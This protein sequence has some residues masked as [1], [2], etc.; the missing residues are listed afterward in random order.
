MYYLRTLGSAISIGLMLF[1]LGC[2]ASGP[3]KIDLMPAPEVYDEETLTPFVDLPGAAEAP[4]WGMLYATDRAPVDPDA[5]QPSKERFYEKERGHLVR[6]GIADIELGEG[7]F[8]WEE[9]R[10]ISL[11]KN[12]TDQYP[13]KVTAVDELGVLDRSFSGFEAPEALALK[14]P[15]PAQRF[16]A[17]INE[18]LA[19][20]AQ[21]DIFVCIHGY[22][23]VFD[24]PILVAME[25]WHYLGYEGVFVAYAWPS[26]PSRWAYFADAETAM[27]TAYGLRIFLEYL[28]EETNAERIHIIGYSQGTRSLGAGTA[29]FAAAPG[30]A[31]T[32]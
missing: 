32:C 9:A 29:I 8:S 26:T 4:Y 15:E 10:Q 31:A 6:L 13:L 28:A 16:A 2:A 14:S 24:N 23:V 22:K 7:D 17:F 5:D 11:A 27:T 19:L 25:L 21:K 30:Q 12:R 20:S 18:K 1:L 3:Y